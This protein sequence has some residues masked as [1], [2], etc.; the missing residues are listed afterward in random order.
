M[1]RP[2]ESLRVMLL[3]VLAVV[4][5][6]PA[7]NAGAINKALSREMAARIAARETMSVAEREALARVLRDLDGRT[8]RILEARFGGYIPREA[9][10]A[11]ERNPVTFL[12]DAAFK[13]W[14]QKASPQ[15]TR[16]EIERTLGATNTLTR[17]ATVD[18]NHVL[19]ARS[20]A[21]ER[22][23]QLSNPALG[24]RMGRDLDE[25]LTDYFAARVTSDLHI[26]SVAVGY[27]PQRELAGMLAARIGEGPLA[28][29][30]FRGDLQTLARAL[31]R[32]LGPGSS[33]A[34]Q[35]HLRRQDLSGARAVLLGARP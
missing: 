6:A 7:A 5:A 15:M 17:S 24:L 22:L 18:Q 32:E 10:A 23:H 30:Y 26:P 2:A 21:H 34:L 13:D 1:S 11:A 3:A 35:A 31:D 29:A 20:V 27:P 33:A 4:L 9:L 28:Q 25:G 16:E 14:L 19:L 8:L 12:D